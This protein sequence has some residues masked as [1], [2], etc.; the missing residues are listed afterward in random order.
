MVDSSTPTRRTRKAAKADRRRRRGPAGVNVGKLH[1]TNPT[2]GSVAAIACL[3][4]G[5]AEQKVAADYE[6]F[7]MAA[8]TFKHA[9]DHAERWW[10]YSSPLAKR[11]IQVATRLEQRL[12]RHLPES[13]PQEKLRTLPIPV[14]AMQ[15]L[16]RSRASTPGPSFADRRA[17]ARR[18]YSRGG[19]GSKSMSRSASRA[20]GISVK[21][22][23]SY[24]YTGSS[25]QHASFCEDS[26]DECDEVRVDFMKP[27]PG[28]VLESLNNEFHPGD[29]Y[30]LDS[31]GEPLMSETSSVLSDAAW[32]AIS[33]AIA[34]DV[35]KKLSR[36]GLSREEQCVVA[37][38]WSKRD[39]FASRGRARAN[40]PNNISRNQPI[41]SFR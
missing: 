11:V 32:S 9:A 4:H 1:A 14:A 21:V 2:F 16:E 36:A 41:P 20:G 30:D 19:P 10:D 35:P 3:V 40:E 18:A 26:D 13:T 34:H 37:H 39:G 5:R 24:N 23:Q 27:R 38:E 25:L 22:S 28:S 7:S 33:G 12:L 31:E 17:A 8:R 15:A 29:F 6:T